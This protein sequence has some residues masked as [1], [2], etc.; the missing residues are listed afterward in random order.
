MNWTKMDACAVKLYVHEID[1]AYRDPR[2]S[3][4]RMK[5][6]PTTRL[7]KDCLRVS[8][9]LDLCPTSQF[10]LGHVIYDR[11]R[12]HPCRVR[13][14]SSAELFYIP[15]FSPRFLRSYVRVL[16]RK[17]LFDTLREPKRDG[18]SAFAARAGCDHFIV[19]PRNGAEF[20]R[21]P[22][23]ELDYEDPRFNRTIRVSIE[24]ALDGRTPVFRTP[25]R[26]R[27][28]YNGIP[29]PSWVRVGTPWMHAH[30]RANLVTAGFGIHGPYF[31]TRVRQRL[32]TLCIADDACTFIPVTKHRG[33]DTQIYL[34]YYQSTF[35]LQPPGDAITRRGVVD[36]LLLGCIPVLFHPG[37]LDMWP[38][39]FGWGRNAS[40]LIPTSR[41][42]ET[43]RI[44]KAVGPQEV[45]RIRSSIRENAH[46]LVYRFHGD[47]EANDDA[48]SILLTALKANVPSCEASA[49]ASA[50]TL[51]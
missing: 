41:Y 15:A 21:K 42:G 47:G 44:L 30:P 12:L 18:A 37:Q 39:H 46:K 40:I 22:F 23:H 28:L 10:A 13:D 36:S 29:Y 50:A 31:T 33:N 8:D 35:C 25:Y 14:A 16:P 4:E 17:L 51:P 2:L 20:E 1:P 7:A 19:Q 26:A 3:Y 27:S 34:S 38:W 11:L 43:M 49:S 24:N 48:V 5:D 9:T 6:I 45:E 32:R